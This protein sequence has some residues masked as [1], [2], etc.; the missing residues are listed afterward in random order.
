MDPISV[1][2]STVL[3]AQS[4]KAAM[5]TIQKNNDSAQHLYQRIRDAVLLL[6]AAVCEG[7]SSSNHQR[8]TALKN[9]MERLT[10]TL[11]AARDA[12]YKYLRAPWCEPSNCFL[13]CF[14][15]VRQ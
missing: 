15:S 11:A 9:N 3:V 8:N 6:E 4:I 2:T 13:L 12:I 14:I 10:H 7:L 5:D 1:L